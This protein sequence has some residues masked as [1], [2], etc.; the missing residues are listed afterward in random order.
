MA[1]QRSFNS[2]KAEWPVFKEASD[3]GRPK[4]AGGALPIERPVRPWNTPFAEVVDK[5]TFRSAIGTDTRFLS[6]ASP[7]KTS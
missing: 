6:K 7:R 1:C 5:W 4:S 2:P 3:P